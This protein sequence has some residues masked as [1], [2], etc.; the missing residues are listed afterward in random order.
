[1][2]QPRITQQIWDRYQQSLKRL[3]PRS[4]ANRLCVVR[5]LCEYL[6][7]TDPLNY[8]PE[9]C[10]APSSREA[11]RPYIFTDEQVKALLAAALNLPPAGSLRPDTY[12]TLL[13]LLYTTGIRVGEA[14]ALNIEHFFPDNQRLYVAAGKFRKARWVVLSRSTTG[15]LSRYLARRIDNE[16][17]GPEAPLLLNE[18]RQRLCHPTVHKGFMELLHASGIPWSRQTGPRLHDWRHYA[19]FR[20]MPSKSEKF[21]DSGAFRSSWHHI[22]R[23][24]Q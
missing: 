3:A 9:P 20:I 8:A 17:N 19:E 6:A 14:F 4:R 11:R 22:I 23:F 1:M 2:Q 5:Q 7:R 21:A 24:N 10:R 15:A 13:G 16:P 18:R 12:H